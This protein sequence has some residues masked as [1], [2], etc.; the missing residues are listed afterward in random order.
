MQHALVDVIA[1]IQAWA[2]KSNHQPFKDAAAGWVDAIETQVSGDL[3]MVDC[4]ER[5]DSKADA[6]ADAKHLLC[7]T[8]GL[9]LDMPMAEVLASCDAVFRGFM[10]MPARTADT[11]A[12]E[13]RTA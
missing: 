13:R 12:A 7:E 4:L 5:L 1:D 6:I 10:G 11:S 8:M 2:A 9:D 3:Q